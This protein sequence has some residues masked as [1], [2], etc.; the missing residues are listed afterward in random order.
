MTAL[1]TTSDSAYSKAAGYDLTTY[2]REE[3]DLDGP[4]ALAV[5][6]TDQVSDET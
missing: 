3:G 6:I 5:A 1:L 2:D 4:F